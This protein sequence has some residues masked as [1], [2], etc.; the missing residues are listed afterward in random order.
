M[1]KKA[2]FPGK[3]NPPHMGHARS[4]LRLNLEY[5]LTV[6]VTADTPPG[7]PF[8]PDQI[9]DEIRSLGVRAETM[10]GV[11]VE[12]EDNPFDPA[13]VVVSGNQKVLEWAQRVGA[14]CRYWPRQGLISGRMI[15]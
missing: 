15:R 5:D 3:F 4:I 12:S 8:T 10:P 2:V 11:L 9:A 7:A 14:P 13:S 1:R 6:I